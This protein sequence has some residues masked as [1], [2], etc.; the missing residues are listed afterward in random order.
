N[1]AMARD[2]DSSRLTLVE[3]LKRPERLNTAQRYR[4]E[5]EA[6]YRLNYDLPA[7]VRWYALHLEHAPQSISGH[8]N[9]GVYL[10]SLGRYEEAVEEFRKAAEIDPFGRAQAQIQLFNEAAI[11][12]A[13][14]RVDQ[15][16]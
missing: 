15:A 12:V 7:A 8:N 14:G 10:S 16:A 3:A 9:L 4:L 13:L 1:F 5:A 11:L 6:A 2:D